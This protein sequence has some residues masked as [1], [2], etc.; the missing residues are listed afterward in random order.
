[1]NWLLDFRFISGNATSQL[2]LRDH[3]AHSVYV[4]GIETER[5][6]TVYTIHKSIL[7]MVQSYKA[8]SISIRCDLSQLDTFLANQCV[9]LAIVQQSDANCRNTKHTH[10]HTATDIDRYEFSIIIIFHSFSHYLFVLCILLL[11]LLVLS[12]VCHVL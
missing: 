8:F 5:I 10:T 9:V 1:M 4:N 7:F 2:H 3:F 12:D 6:T 11:L